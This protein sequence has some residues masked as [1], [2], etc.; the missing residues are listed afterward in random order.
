M[1]SSPSVVVKKGGFFTALFHG[2]F[3]L[4]AVL[5]LTAGILGFYAL[6]IADRTSSDLLQI[7]GKI[8]TDMP[9]WAGN[10][11]PVLAEALDDHRA[12]DYRKELDVVAHLLPAGKEDDQRALVIEVT[13]KGTQTVSVLALNVVVE[14]T[15]GVPLL[16]RRVYVATPFVVDEDD[17]RGPLMPGSQRRFV[18]DQGQAPH[19]TVHTEIAELRVW[20]GGP[21]ASAQNR[22]ETGA[23]PATNS[24]ETSAAGVPVTAT[25]AR[26]DL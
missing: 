24:G 13:N 25:T 9:N 19:C 18:V 11:P 20:N 22:P 4:L 5:V 17:W 7:S 8:I 1:S 21:D 12:P 3:G 14:D 26:Q 23:K 15:A 16:E 2:V 10:L 6:H